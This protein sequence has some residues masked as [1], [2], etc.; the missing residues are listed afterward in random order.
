MEDLK[1][2]MTHSHDYKEF[3]WKDRQ[4]IFKKMAQ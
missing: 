2:K 1:K 4:T 3:K